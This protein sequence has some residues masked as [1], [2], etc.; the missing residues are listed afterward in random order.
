MPSSI[1]PPRYLFRPKAR[2]AFRSK[3]EAKVARFLKKIGFD[4][5]YE[6]AISVMDDYGLDRIW[7]PD[8]QIAPHLLLEVCGMTGDSRYTAALERKL[9]VYERHGYMVIAVKP[10]MIRGKHWE[11]RLLKM[12]HLFMSNWFQRYAGGFRKSHEQELLMGK[13]KSRIRNLNSKRG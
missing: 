7:H 9:K 12:I 8:F 1:N 4:Y 10:H 11:T 2:Q 13:L 3:G 6:P 5:L